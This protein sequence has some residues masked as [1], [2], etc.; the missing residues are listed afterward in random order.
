MP[1]ITSA[2]VAICGT[3]FGETK[4]AASTFGK[5]AADSRFTSSILTSAEIVCASFCSPSRGPTSTI[6]TDFGSDAEDSMKSESD[7]KIQGQAGVDYDDVTSQRA[8][9]ALLRECMPSFFSRT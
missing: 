3:H 6:L 7:S 2:D 9:I 8:S 5:P 1:A 4:E